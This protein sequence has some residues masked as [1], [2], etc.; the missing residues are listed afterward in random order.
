MHGFS[1]I[2]ILEEYFGHGRIQLFLQIGAL[3]ID[4]KII[5]GVPYLDY[6]YQV[7]VAIGVHAHNSI[8]FA[9]GHL[10]IQSNIAGHLY[11]LHMYIMLTGP[12]LEEP[13]LHTAS[14]HTH[15]FSL[16]GLIIFRSNFGIFVTHIDIKFFRTHR[17]SGVEHFS[18]T[19][20]GDRNIAHK[21]NFALLEH[22]HQLRPISPHIFVLPT[23]IILDILLEVIGIA[24]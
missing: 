23:R 5:I 15:T 18:Q 8:Q 16:Q 1:I 22:F 24:T 19:L 6:G 21:V 20:F 4:N 13:H 12:L 7:M 11:E 14:V 3:L 17:D 2:A 9:T 10:L